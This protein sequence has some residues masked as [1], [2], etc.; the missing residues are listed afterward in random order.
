MLPQNNPDGIRIVFDGHRLVAQVLACSCP[1]SP[2]TWA[3]RKSGRKRI[4]KS[5]FN[6]APP[7]QYRTVNKG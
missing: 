3:W 1:S 7:I 5:M 6:S 4:G 2:S